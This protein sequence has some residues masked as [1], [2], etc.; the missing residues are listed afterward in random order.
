LTTTNPCRVTI[1]SEN[2]F[3]ELSAQCFCTFCPLR[4]GI[5]PT[6]AGRIISKLTLIIGM[7]MTDFYGLRR[8]IEESRGLGEKSLT[9]F[10]S[11]VAIDSR[12]E[13]GLATDLELVELRVC[14]I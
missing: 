3:I 7:R 8:E 13:G 14:L 11:D 4:K 1:S 9:C 5:V 6:E 10:T 12:L 2:G